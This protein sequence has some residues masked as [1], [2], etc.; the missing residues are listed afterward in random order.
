MME[1]IYKYGWYAM[2]IAMVGDMLIP[3]ILSPFYRGYSN[4]KMSISS[5]GNPK[6]PVR[7]PFNLW[8][9]TEGTLFLIALP[10]LY[11]Y[12]HPIS[13][14]ITNI[15]IVFITIFAV[16][17]CIFTCFFS[18]NERKD[19]VTTTSKIHGIG[20]VLGFM[21]FLWVPLLIGLLLLK[22]EEFVIGI[23]SILCFIV[24][25][26]FFVLFIMSDKPKF[27]N[28][29]IQNEGLWQ[30]LNLLFMYLPLCMVT[31][32]KLLEI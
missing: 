27:S 26:F 23:I 12:Y 24:A 16:G 15:T 14:A 8:M 21:L 13:I 1:Y 9:L 20:S 18:V 6:S 2:L 28:T 3:F 17:S 32:Q 5:L 10:T 25:F 7:L 11:K 19:I 29:I 22:E 31:I 4:I 30:R